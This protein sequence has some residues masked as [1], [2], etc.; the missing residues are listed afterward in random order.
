MF[1]PVIRPLFRTILQI[2]SLVLY[3]LTILA[4]F[5]GHIN[6]Q[7]FAIPAI[8]VMVL[9]YL[10]MLSI[11]VTILWFLAGRWIFGG[12]GVLSLIL[13][14]GSISSVLPF[15]FSRN[16]SPDKQSFSLM[17][18]NFLHGW[19]QSSYPNQKGNQAL[20]Y[21]I[22]SDVDLSLIHI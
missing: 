8:M 21:I 10:A 16:P 12:V 14:W 6:P 17:T 7:Y 22:N 20:E 4:A 5:G 1:L 9:P 11:T 3:A 2:A 18:W 15:R 13:A 19:D